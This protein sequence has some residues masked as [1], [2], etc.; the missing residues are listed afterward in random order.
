MADESFDIV[1]SM[2]GFHAFPDKKKAFRET[3]R[4][5]RKDGTFIGCFYI[6]GKSKRTDWLVK[7]ILSK[8]GWFTPPFPTEAQLKKILG[9]LYSDVEFHVDG[10]MA[11]F[12][13]VK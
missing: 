2:N 9:R 5:L 8:K 10:S 1:V 3:Y 4:V 6:R 12:R 11:Y 13:C 7:S